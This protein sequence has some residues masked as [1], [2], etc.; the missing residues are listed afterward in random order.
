MA[1]ISAGWK[2][3]SMAWEDKDGYSPYDHTHNCYNKVT[4]V[5]CYY[6]N[7]LCDTVDIGTITVGNVTHHMRMP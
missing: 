1:D 2:F 6:E 3:G 4:G 7:D 5:S